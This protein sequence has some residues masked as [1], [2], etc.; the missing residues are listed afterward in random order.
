[1]DLKSYLERIEAIRPEKP[2]FAGLEYLQRQHLLTVP[3]ENLDILRKI[4]IQLDESQIYDKV[5][6]RHRGGF[7]YE[8]NGLFYRLLESLGY[9]TRL[10]AGTVKKEEGWALADSHATLLVELDGWWLVDVGFGDSARLPLPLTGEERTDVSGRYRVVPVAEQEGV[11]DLQRKRASESWLTRL[12]FS[13]TPKKLWEFAPQCQFNQTSPD[14]PFTGKS[15]VTLPTT[16]GRI[17]LSGNTLVV[18]QGDTKQKEEIPSSSL[19]QLLRER[20]GIIL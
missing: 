8:L 10:V 17:T 14:S 6:H 3:F 13:T 7:C 16:E 15:V 2:D 19:P 20:F 11:Y 5:V 9:Q 4:P 12:R 18:T 1:M